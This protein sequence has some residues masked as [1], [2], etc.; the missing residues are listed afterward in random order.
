MKRFARRLGIRTS[1]SRQLRNR[2]EPFAPKMDRIVDGDGYDADANHGGKEDEGGSFEP[3][4]P[5]EDSESI[6]FV[7][8]GGAM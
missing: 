8:I 6:P 4:S 2:F 3:E 5:Y 1:V 7:G